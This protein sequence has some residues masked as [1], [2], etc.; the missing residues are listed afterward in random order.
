MRPRQAGVT[1]IEVLIA[2]TL[3]SLLSLAMLFAMRVGFSAYAKTNDKLMANRKVAGAQ[4]ILEDELEGLIPAMPPCA[5]N[6]EGAGAPTFVLF[7]G[8]PQMMR[9]VSAY[10]LQQAWRGQ[11]QL[12]ELFVIPGDQGRGVRLVVNETPYSSK[13]GGKVCTGIGS[14]AAGPAVQFTPATAGPQS[15]VLADQLAFCRFSY[16]VPPQASA[17]NQPSPAVW[18]P[19]GTGR[20]WPQAI[21]I[22]MAPLEPDP[23]RLQPITVTAPIYIHRSPQITYVDKMPH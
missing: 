4:R 16:R 14:A 7:Q 19:S 18:S 5:G 1:L 12:L 6:G 15:F 2:V 3:L 13:I 22:E 17:P 10:S 20:G 11:P 21:R 9:L 8:E 23:S